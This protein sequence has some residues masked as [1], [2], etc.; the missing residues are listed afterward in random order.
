VATGVVEVSVRNAGAD[1]LRVDV[2]V[3]GPPA[4][5]AVGAKNRKRTIA[6]AAERIVGDTVDVCVR[7]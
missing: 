5:I 1:P 4:A 3:V 7:A 6:S 2:V